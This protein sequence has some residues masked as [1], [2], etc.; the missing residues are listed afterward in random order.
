MKSAKNVDKQIPQ[1]WNMRGQSRIQAHVPTTQKPSPNNGIDGVLPRR[2]TVL[3][4]VFR[5]ADAAAR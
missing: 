1:L 3:P 4:M 5:G 2:N